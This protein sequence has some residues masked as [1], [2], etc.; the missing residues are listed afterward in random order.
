MRKSEQRERPALLVTYVNANVVE[1]TGDFFHPKAAK[2]DP[3]IS[4]GI[5]VCT[6]VGITRVHQ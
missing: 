2:A 6:K 5:A 1:S 4:D 3:F